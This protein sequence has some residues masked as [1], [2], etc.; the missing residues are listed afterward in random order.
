MVCLE[1]L[2]DEILL[3]IYRYLYSFD[4]LY[5]FTGLNQ[6]IEQSLLEYQQHVDL[7]YISLQQFAYFIIKLL[8]MFMDNVTSLVL[9]DEWNNGKPLSYAGM[10]PQLQK[11]TVISLH[12][13]N[14]NWLLDN[15]SFPKLENLNVCREAISLAV[16]N[17][18]EPSTFLY[19]IQN[20]KRIDMGNF[21]I[22]FPY[23]VYVV[24]NSIEHMTI[25]VYEISN[26]L[27][28]LECSPCLRYFKGFAALDEGPSKPTG[29][30]LPHLHEFHLAISDE[31]DWVWSTLVMVIQCLPS[32]LERLSFA[33]AAGYESDW[34]DG[35]AWAQAIP[36]HVRSFQLML[37]S[38]YNEIL[39][40]LVS[41]EETKQSWLTSFWI[42]EKHCYIQCFDLQ[43]PQPHYVLCTYDYSDFGSF[44]DSM[45]EAKQ[46]FNLNPNGN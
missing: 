30:Q 25:S 43:S 16:D 41:L 11:L 46:I 9:D 27:A 19:Q 4:I 3:L 18:C 33:G 28:I 24:Q 39:P 26:V 5:A 7:R 15:N 8:P 12:H 38:Y 42:D 44:K 14:L 35:N 17:K 21:L 45:A 32:T 36:T 37:K 31:G 40:R 1:D 29:I 23:G 2:P 20:L 10:L 6:R 34:L 13:V 22:D